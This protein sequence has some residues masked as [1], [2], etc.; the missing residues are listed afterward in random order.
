MKLD[1]ET[2][3]QARALHV[4][5]DAKLGASALARRFGVS[6]KT[7]RSA[8]S[9][10]SWATA[11]IPTERNDPAAVL[12]DRVRERF[13][14]CVQ[15]SDGCW[16]WTGDF[17][18]NGYGRL[19][20]KGKRHSAHRLSWEFAHGSLPAD[21][22]ICH[23]CDTP[24]CVR[25]DHLFLGTPGDNSRDMVAKARHRSRG[26]M[27]KPE[28]VNDIRR[29]HLNGETIEALMADVGACRQT[30]S[31]IVRWRSWK[32]LQPAGPSKASPE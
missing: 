29:R 23:R 30:I 5:G 31:N 18:V 6:P 26:A 3:A 13:W 22:F 9:G 11:P 19:S 4:K 10:E 25:P 32:K 8:L 21:Q 14:S 28:V 15:K 12:R 20:I 1:A 16:L 7:M 24:A 27:L 2:V 17:A